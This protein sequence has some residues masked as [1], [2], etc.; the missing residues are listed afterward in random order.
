M[1]ELPVI[2]RTYEVYKG[3]AVILPVLPKQERYSIGQSCETSVLTLLENLIMAKHAPKAQKTSYL[4]RASAQHEIAV[5]KLRLILE[6]KL[7]NET[8]VLKLQAKLVE[9]GRMLG[10]WRKSITT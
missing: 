7:A 4:I 5:L 8:N 3:L 1:E 9:V 10:G 2:N 6:L